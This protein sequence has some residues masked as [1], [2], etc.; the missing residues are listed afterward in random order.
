MIKNYYRLLIGDIWNE[1]V[2]S[3]LHK[4]FAL[5]ETIKGN[6]LSLPTNCRRSF[7]GYNPIFTD[8]VMALQKLITL[9][10]YTAQTGE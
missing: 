1:P 2:Y 5:E 8:I 6:R 7:S 3:V 10:A 4:L 9:Y